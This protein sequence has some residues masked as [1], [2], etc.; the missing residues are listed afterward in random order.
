MFHVLKQ[1]IS[2]VI[3]VRFRPPHH[4]GKFPEKTLAI[5][6]ILYQI[7][8][9]CNHATPPMQLYGMIHLCELRGIF[10]KLDLAVM[11]TSAVCHDLDHPG[12][13]NK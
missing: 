13:N 4:F 5:I 11:I 7:S 6:I 9:H 2:T 8:F 12:F 1:P 3:T 10:T